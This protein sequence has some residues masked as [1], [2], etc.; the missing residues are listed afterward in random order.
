MDYIYIFFILVIC[1][2]DIRKYKTL[3]TPISVLFFPVA[4]LTFINNIFLPWDFYKID[5]FS[6]KLIFFTAIIFIIPSLFWKKTDIKNTLDIKEDKKYIEI[7]CIL[8]FVALI[9]RFF[10]DIYK[11]GGLE[12]FEM[13]KLDRKNTFFS[14]FVE[15]FSIFIPLLLIYKER[16]K[17]YLFVLFLFVLLLFQNKNR[18][19]LLI[20]ESLFLIDAFFSVKLKKILKYICFIVIV[21]FVIYNLKGFSQA[22]LNLNLK[23]HNLEILRHLYLYL[24]SPLINIKIFYINSLKY[25]SINYV[26]IP[27]IG[28]MNKFSIGNIKNPNILYDFYSVS[29]SGESSNVG[30]IFGEVLY[31]NNFLI[32]ILFFVCLSIVSY[33]IFNKRRKNI[34]YSLLSS[35]LLSTLTLSFFSN[36]YNLL[37]V[38]KRIFLIFLI[39]IIKKIY[40]RGWKL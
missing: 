7:I 6:I 24:V 17:N 23:N 40:K 15:F 30:S 25:G 36:I 21:F 5:S 9:C 32:Y 34:Y 39:I 26:F 16:K 19:F 38:W 20:L 10:F 13:L 29:K 22:G 8:T 4:T 2:F 11:L 12:Q 33:Y 18:V 35:F 31:A 1:I 3:L 14:N 37:F 28:I 27:I